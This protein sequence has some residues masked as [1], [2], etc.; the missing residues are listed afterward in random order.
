MEDPRNGI[1]FL[2]L[3]TKIYGMGIKNRICQGCSKVERTGSRALKCRLCYEADKTKLLIGRERKELEAIY[4]GVVGPTGV[5]HN[6]RI[7]SFIHNECGTR[8]S[9]IFINVKKQLKLR[10]GSIPCSKCGGKE[11]MR[12][13]LAAFIEKYGRDFDVGLWEEYKV[14]ARRMSE[15]TYKAN[16]QEINP[17]NL[18]RG[19]RTYHLDHIIS[20][21]EG[22]LQGIPVEVIAA[23]ENLQILKAFENLSKGR[24]SEQQ[25]I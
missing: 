25:Q 20:I 23:K 2:C 6:H 11:R 1:L 17:L 15:R 9:M 16:E 18:K 22:F 7:Y 12:P 3:E 24:K 4:G 5:N 8:Q 13:A 10:P 14:A 19:V 21:I